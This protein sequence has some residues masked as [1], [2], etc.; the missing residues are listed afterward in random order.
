[1]V[2]ITLDPHLN[3]GSI[4][5]RNLG[6]RHEES[7]ADLA[8]EQRVKPLPLLLLVAVFGEHLHVAGIWGRA[9]DS[10]GRD[11]ALAQVLC[12]EPVLEVAEA[13]ALLEVCL[14]QEHV[15]DSELLGSLLHVLDDGRVRREAFLGRLADLAE[16]YGVGG[17]T[18]F[19]DE[20]LYLN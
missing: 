7:R 15:P 2:A 11:P 5:R 12:H 20:S 19:F 18:F 3:V 8:P 6:L 16:V 1:V 10:L 4:T 13:S 9:I 14:G 17:D